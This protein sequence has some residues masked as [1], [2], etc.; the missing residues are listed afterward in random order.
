MADYLYQ[1]KPIR[2]DLLAGSASRVEESDTIGQH[3]E[4]PSTLHQA[5]VVE[6]ARRTDTDHENT[7]GIVLQN[8]GSESS[9]R[10]ILEEDPAVAGRG[11]SAS[12]YPFRIAVGTLARP[13]E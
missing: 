7:F 12:L 8:T 4:Y 10:K 9:A 1:L 13:P 2:P 6:L 5:G 11:M 3:F